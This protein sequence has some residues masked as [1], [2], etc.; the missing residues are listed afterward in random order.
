MGSIT[1]KLH[2]DC[3]KNAALRIASSYLEHMK[4]AAAAAEQRLRTS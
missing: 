2:N 3:V 4:A 1:R